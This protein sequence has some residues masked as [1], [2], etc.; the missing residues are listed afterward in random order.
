MPVY[1]YSALN[2]HGK[3]VKGTV[4]AENPRAARSR[5]RSQG[6]YATDI[7][8]GIEAASESRTRD[9]R[10]YFRIERISGA[11]RAVATR[12][13]ATLV[14]AGLPLVGALHAL[15]EQTDSPAFKRVLVK[16]RE[17]VEEGSSLARALG[18]F[19]RVFSRLYVNLVASGEAS[20]K[21]DTVL[22]NLADYQEAQMELR[23]RIGAALAYPILMLLVCLAVIAGLL[24]YVVPRIVEIFQK[25]NLV[26]PLPTRLVL[27]ASHIIVNY[28]YLLAALLIL[29]AYAV[30][31]AYRRPAGRDYI[32]RQLLRLP[33]FGRLYLKIGVARVTRT[34]STLLSSGVDLL[35][36]LD[37]S[38]NI[39]TNV[40]LVRALEGAR[41]GVREG[42]A[43]ATELGR[44]GVFPNLL[45][46]M[47]AVG[48][49]SGELENML[50]RASRAYENEVNAAL[51]GLTALLEPLLTIMVGAVVLGIVVSVLLPMAEMIGK[52]Q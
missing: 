9:I 25:Q 1:E 15:S 11:E 51:S 5:L 8:E 3:T 14:A 52:I 24:V 31:T 46:H 35:T 29:I 39:A 17:D 28:W 26:L 10:R 22:E 49:K 37:I 43:L 6:I 44:S 48:E 18:N 45:C 33:V 50:T 2:T 27:G 23:R 47:I 7:R 16:V 38:K 4:D 42:H 21:L 13:L 32:D 34:L 19:P 30:V 20:G 12:Q 41:D 40:H 36:G